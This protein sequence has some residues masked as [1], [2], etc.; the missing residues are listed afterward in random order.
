MSD[1]TSVYFIAFGTGDQR[2]ANTVVGLLGGRE[3]EMIYFR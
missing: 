2:A 1:L 3:R